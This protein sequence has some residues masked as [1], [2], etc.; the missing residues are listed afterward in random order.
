MDYALEP[1]DG[2]IGAAVV[3]SYE[4][5]LKVFSRRGDEITLTPIETKRHS[6]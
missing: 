2:D 6:T 3:D 4:S 5:T 1:H